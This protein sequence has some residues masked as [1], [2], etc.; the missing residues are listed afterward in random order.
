MLI[1]N[2]FLESQ[3]TFYSVFKKKFGWNFVLND[4]TL[5]VFNNKIIGKFRD[6]YDFYQISNI[7]FSEKKFSELRKIVSYNFLQINS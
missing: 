1:K 3:S 2:I 5:G 7:K 6:F 4:T